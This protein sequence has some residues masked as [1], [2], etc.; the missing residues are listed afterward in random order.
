MHKCDRRFLRTVRRRGGV[1]ANKFK[2][3]QTKETMNTNK[4]VPIDKKK[5]KEQVG[6]NSF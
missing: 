1:R 6:D 5:R 2:V 4:G 3:Q